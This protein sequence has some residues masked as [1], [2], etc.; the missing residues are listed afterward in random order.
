MWRGK[1]VPNLSHF[2]CTRH[3]NVDGLSRR[4]FPEPAIW[5]AKLTSPVS[6]D[7]RVSGPQHIAEE[8]L[9]R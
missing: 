2:F 4:D 1:E 8:Q 9:S 6:F 7:L 3:L 5:R